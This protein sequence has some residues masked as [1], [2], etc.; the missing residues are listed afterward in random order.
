MSLVFFIRNVNPILV[1]IFDGISWKFTSEN[2]SSFYLSIYAVSVEGKVLEIEGA[3]V[4][5]INTFHSKNYKGFNQ[6]ITE[7]LGAYTKV[8]RE[9][10][11]KSKRWIG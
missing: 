11:E 8:T 4:L 9:F 2:K 6:Q 7:M 3:P 10:I 5:C 1:R